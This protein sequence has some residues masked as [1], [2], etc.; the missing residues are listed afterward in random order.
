MIFFVE[1]IH[2]IF[3]SKVRQPDKADMSGKLIFPYPGLFRKTQSSFAKHVKW[4]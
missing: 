3:E 1:M 2:F 4:S